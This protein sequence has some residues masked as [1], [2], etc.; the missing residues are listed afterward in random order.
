MKKILLVTL[1]IIV[2]SIFISST[3][4]SDSNGSKGPI[5]IAVSTD[6]PSFYLIDTVF[7]LCFYVSYMNLGT[8]AIRIPCKPFTALIPEI[9][10]TYDKCQ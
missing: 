2:S 7:D 10:D 8:T 4:R 3:A 9:S 1:A 5:T 6:P